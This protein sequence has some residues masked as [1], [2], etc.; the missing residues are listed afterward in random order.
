[1][2]GLGLV[3]FGIGRGLDPDCR[4]ELAL[5]PE[6]RD[7]RSFLEG[8]PTLDVLLLLMESS[9]NEPRKARASPPRPLKVEARSRNKNSVVEG[10]DELVYHW[11]ASGRA[12]EAQS[13]RGQ[14]QPLSD[15]LCSDTTTM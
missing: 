3:V 1:M 13:R 14:A 12:Q 10:W 11:G 6:S 15:G 4:S 7:S 9:F 8:L 5:S 2:T